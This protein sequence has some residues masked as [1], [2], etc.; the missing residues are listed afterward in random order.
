MLGCASAVYS[1]G[2]VSSIG[3]ADGCSAC[4]MTGRSVSDG[5]L[6]VICRG[7]SDLVSAS[8]SACEVG[9]I[10]VAE[11][12]S[13][14]ELGSSGSLGASGDSCEPSLSV[15]VRVCW[16][17]DAHAW[18]TASEVG[19]ITVVT[20]GTEASAPSGGAGENVVGTCVCAREVSG[21]TGADS[22]GDV[23]DW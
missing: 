21:R 16:V 23:N 14:W 7:I 12:T 19:V 13:H 8:V 10:E 22:D 1:G 2:G 4:N 20:G 11:C 6:T 18:C 5:S 15:E 3:T 17:T 9:D